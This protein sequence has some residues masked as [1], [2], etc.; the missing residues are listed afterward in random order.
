MLSIRWKGKVKQIQC[1]LGF[2]FKRRDRKAW[3]VEYQKI[4]SYVKSADKQFTKTIQIV[5]KFRHVKKTS[6]IFWGGLSK[7]S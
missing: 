2:S 3:N 5:K 6:E 1:P 4:S 7:K